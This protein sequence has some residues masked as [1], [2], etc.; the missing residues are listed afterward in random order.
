MCTK[1]INPAV[2]NADWDE[3]SPICEHVYFTMG[4]IIVR[5]KL[6]T[7]GKAKFGAMVI[8][9]EP[10]SLGDRLE[11]QLST[12]QTESLRLL[13]ALLHEALKPA[14]TQSPLPAAIQAS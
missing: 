10:W 9:G 14:I 7:Q 5:G 3:L 13:E 6:V 11:A 4:R 1:F 12:A 2:R 8:G